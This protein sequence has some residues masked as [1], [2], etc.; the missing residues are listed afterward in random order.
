VWTTPS[1]TTHLWLWVPRSQG[2]GGDEAHYYVY[3][4]ASDALGPVYRGGT[5]MG[6]A[7]AIAAAWALVVKDYG[8]HAGGCRGLNAPRSDSAREEAVEEREGGTGQLELIEREKPRMR[9]FSD[10]L[11]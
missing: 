6:M 11:V 8:V 5:M 7:G 1:V 3:I 2:D 4:L 10:L 9:R